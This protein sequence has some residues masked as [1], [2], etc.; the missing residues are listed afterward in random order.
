MPKLRVWINYQPRIYSDILKEVLRTLALID[1]VEVS[2][3]ARSAEENPISVDIALLSLDGLRQ[4]ELDLLPDR[5]REAKVIAFSPKG[6]FGL[7][8]LPG[9][10]NWEEVRPFGMQQ[11]FEELAST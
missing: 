3:G 9:R 6:D 8:R 10:N 1:V 2:T 4:P 7:K 11:L 5:L